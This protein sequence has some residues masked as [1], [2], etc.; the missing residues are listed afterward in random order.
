MEPSW[1]ACTRLFYCD[2]QIKYTFEYKS[3][4]SKVVKKLKV[5]GFIREI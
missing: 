2:I 3:G 5:I 4:S 1:H